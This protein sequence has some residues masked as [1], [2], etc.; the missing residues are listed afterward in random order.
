MDAE[1]SAWPGAGTMAAMDDTATMRPRPR[2]IC[3]QHIAN[4]AVHI[5]P[6][7][8]LLIVLS[9]YVNII[10]HDMTTAFQGSGQGKVL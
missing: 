10:C 3:R 9:I 1:Y 6:I 5:S 7:A 8:E 2:D 4:Q